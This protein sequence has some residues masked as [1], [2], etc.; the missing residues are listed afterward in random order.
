V[1]PFAEIA[2]E[3][4]HATRLVACSH[5]SW[6]SGRIVDTAALGATEAPVLLDAAQALG[7][8]PTRVSELGCDYYACSGQKWLCG[9]EGSGCL[10]IR[11][12]RVDE[13]EIPWPSYAS[14]ADAQR[15]LELEP[16]VGAARFD[17][18][19]PSVLR[20]SWALAAL[21]A[22]REA[23]WEWIYELAASLADRLAQLLTE[24]GIEVLPRGRSTL[25]SFRLPERD[26]EQEVERLAGEG[27]VVRSVPTRAGVIRASVGAWSH[28]DE[29]ER[30]AE[31]I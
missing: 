28:G 20:S 8:L 18:G 10:F 5:V 3:V 29:L 14:L 9:P 22:L 6:V 13:L 19:F 27:I 21:E 11:P 17:L 12:E 25:V 24:R 2:G 1:V 26:A 31:L 15:P 16:A 7:A 23:G 4:R 30:L